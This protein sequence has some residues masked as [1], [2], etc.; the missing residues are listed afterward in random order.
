MRHLGKSHTKRHLI[1]RW[2]IAGC[3][4]HKHLAELVGS[5]TQ[6]MQE[7]GSRSAHMAKTLINTCY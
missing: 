3:G 1:G 7:L 6:G 2:L 5:G 4:G